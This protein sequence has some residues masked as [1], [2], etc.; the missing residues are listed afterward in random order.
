MDILT[1]LFYL[2]T[3]VIIISSMSLVIVSNTVHA[4][5]LLVL[6]FFNSA[7]LW[8]TLKAEF[9]AIVLV[10]VYVGAVLVLFLFVIMLLDIP[11]KKKSSNKLYLLFSVITSFIMFAELYMIIFY[12]DFSNE[13]TTN[14]ASNL[15]NTYEIGYKLFTQ[16]IFSF[17]ITAFILL[18]AIIAAIAINLTQRERSLRQDPGKQ[19]LENKD[20][21]LKV[22]KGD[23][24]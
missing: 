1:I 3:S 14:V 9:L 18:V 13:V 24:L 2:V 7:I 16:Y 20:S 12:H 22:I 5:L 21:R 19:I 15:N 11:V 6:I 23:E 4:A 8:L 17:E 10:L